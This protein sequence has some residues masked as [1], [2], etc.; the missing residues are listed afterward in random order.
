[1]T[2]M[3][4]SALLLL[5][6]TCPF[7]LA[8]TERKFTMEFPAGSSDFTSIV[9][10]KRSEDVVGA[11]M[12]AGRYRFFNAR[13][14]ASGSS[15]ALDVHSAFDLPSSDERITAISDNWFVTNKNSVGAWTATSTRVFPNVLGADVQVT[16]MAESKTRL[17]LISNDNKV[18]VMS[19]DNNDAPKLVKVFEWDQY[20][21]CSVESVF[22]HEQSNRLYAVGNSGGVGSTA[23]VWF[24]TVDAASELTYDEASMTQTAYSDNELLA[25]AW[26]TSDSSAES[27]VMVD[28]A[29]GE[30][31][32]VRLGSMQVLPLEY[33]SKARINGDLVGADRE[34]NA[35]YLD[36]KTA[37]VTV[38]Q[39][40]S[41]EEPH[42]RRVAVETENVFSKPM[43]VIRAFATS[44]MLSVLAREEATAITSITL[45]PKYEPTRHVVT[46]I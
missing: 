10:T 12:N 5:A 8:F 43:T 39:S 15:G 25:F 33:E 27:M 11:F 38:T 21:S 14:S 23:S 40:V 30:S 1:M 24:F 41:D 4:R 37:A 18:Y 46:Y 34:K 44:S 6:L 29:M 16:V 26:L 20:H 9:N 32:M 28:A 7:V 22:F 45:I 42:K 19:T 35:Y 36:T 3:T 17:Y 31:A 2:A 13:V